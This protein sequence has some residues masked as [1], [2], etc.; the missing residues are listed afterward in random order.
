MNFLVAQ[1]I[2]PSLGL[3]KVR[4]G[5]DATRY[6][7]IVGTV[8]RWLLLLLLILILIWLAAISGRSDDCFVVCSFGLS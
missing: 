2:S 1:W 3:A 8:I 6:F 7:C 5:G 4:E